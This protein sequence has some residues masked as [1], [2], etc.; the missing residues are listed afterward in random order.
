MLFFLCPATSGLAGESSL[1]FKGEIL[2]GAVCLQILLALFFLLFSCRWVFGSTERS[3]NHWLNDPHSFLLTQVWQRATEY[4][5]SFASSNIFIGEITQIFE[6]RP[7]I[8]WVSPSLHLTR[9]RRAAGPGCRD[10]GAKALI[11][12]G[13]CPLHQR[14]FPLDITPS[15]EAGAVQRCAAAVNGLGMWPLE[16]S[17]LERAHASPVDEAAT[18]AAFVLPSWDS[19]AYGST[20][21]SSLLPGCCHPALGDCGAQRWGQVQVH[22]QHESVLSLPS[23]N[24]RI[25]QVV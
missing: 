22:M 5:L 15:W 3:M 17:G 14:D 18:A 25:I 11:K 10:L 13:A 9:A 2:W 1:W 21:T 20:G 4:I 16:Q 7:P 12:R 23:Q 6:A 24:H 8:L 19:G